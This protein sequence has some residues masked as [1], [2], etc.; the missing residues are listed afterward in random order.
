MSD[1]LKFQRALFPDLEPRT[2]VLT[3]G[4]RPRRCLVIWADQATDDIRKKAR[5]KNCRF[6][7]SMHESQKIVDDSDLIW[8]DDKG[9]L[10]TWLDY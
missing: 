5:G 2:I 9:S 1:P 4:G 7:I 6:F 10:P 8:E 3:R